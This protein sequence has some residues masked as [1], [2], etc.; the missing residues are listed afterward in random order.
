MRKELNAPVGLIKCAW[1]GT[2][3]EP[4]IPAEAFQQDQEMAAYYDD[5]QSD[6]ENKIASWD[7]K[8]AEINYQ[9]AVKRWNTKQRGQKPQKASK[10]KASQ[11]FPSTLFNGMVNPVIPYAIR[12]TIWYLSLIQ[13]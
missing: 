7:P 1:G 12:G 10:P 4:W 8:Q 11:Q 13:I 6:L 9:D 3:V 2:R 5:I